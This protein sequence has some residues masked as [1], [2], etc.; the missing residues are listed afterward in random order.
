MK[1]SKSMCVKLILW[2]TQILPG[3]GDFFEAGLRSA[4]H[5]KMTLITAGKLGGD[6]SRETGM[7][8]R[9]VGRRLR[10]ILSSAQTLEG[11]SAA[12]FRQ[13]KPKGGGL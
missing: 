3:A 9:I 1:R 6:D 11:K 2:Y 5:G 12:Y 8:I 10:E 4:A 13:R 7:G